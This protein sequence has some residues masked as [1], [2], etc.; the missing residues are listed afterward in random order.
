MNSSPFTSLSL[1]LIGVILILSALLDYI[2]LAIPFNWQDPQWQIGF[3]SSI[4]DRGIVPMVGI[5][6]LLIGYWIDSSSGVAAPRSST[7]D[8]RLPVFVLASILGLFFLLFVPI[9]LNNLNQAKN[10]ALEQIDKGAGQGE[11]QIQSF[12]TQINA[13]SQNP[14]QLNQEILQRTQ[15]LETGQLQ[16]RQLAP[17]Q[18]EALR[19]QRD[20][21]QQLRDLAKS[22][23]Q[24]KERLETLKKQLQTRL[25][26][27]RREREN[28]AKT[29][30][31]KQGLRVGLSSLM[32]AIGYT[33]IGWFGLR[34][35]GGSSANRPKA[36]T[37]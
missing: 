37:R 4:V 33:A 28:L 15:V 30:A 19:Q 9:H 8:L 17:Q 27:Q 25:L 14:Q 1:K 32:L 21:L 36:S 5:A 7:L 22:P 24:L 18:I 34:G 2:V 29:E 12:L 20:Q 6:C 23:K 11:E 31:L 26:D 16:G 35:I 3:V 10:T 13:V